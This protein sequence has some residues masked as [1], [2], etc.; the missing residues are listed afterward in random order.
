MMERWI[1][2]YFGA[3]FTL[4]D[5]RENMNSAEAAEDGPSDS[6]TDAFFKTGTMREAMDIHRFIFITL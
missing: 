2:I 1:W 4:C 3:I 6:D 5:L